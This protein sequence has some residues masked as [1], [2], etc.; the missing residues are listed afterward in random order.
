MNT[1]QR[2]LPE[3]L[4]YLFSYSYEFAFQHTDSTWSIAKKV[5]FSLIR[6]NCLKVTCSGES[7]LF[8]GVEI[9]QN[10]IEL[11]LFVLKKSGFI[12]SFHKVSNV[13]YEMVLLRTPL[14]KAA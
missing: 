7:G 2:L 5:T 10:K 12:T 6:Q 1:T 14:S 3:A 4:T 11:Y 9:N 8:H 13:T